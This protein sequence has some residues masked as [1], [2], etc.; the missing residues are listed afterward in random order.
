[1]QTPPHRLWF[2]AMPVEAAAEVAALMASRTAPRGLPGMAGE[3]SAVAAAAAR[4]AVERPDERLSEIRA[5]RIYALGTLREPESVPGRARLATE[6]DSERLLDW[7][8]RSRRRRTR[9]WPTS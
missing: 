6:D 5:M 8:G 2:S 1:M 3:R 9:S 7:Q 4:W